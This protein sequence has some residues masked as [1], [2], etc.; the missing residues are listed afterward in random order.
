MLSAHS[1]R[2][3]NSCND[4]TDQD[5]EEDDGEKLDSIIAVEQLQ[6]N[7]FATLDASLDLLVRHSLEK[8]INDMRLMKADV[9]N[10][11]EL[12]IDECE[13]SQIK[14]EINS[15]QTTPNQTTTA[16]KESTKT[17]LFTIENIIKK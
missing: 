4:D 16:T 8:S 5:V 12:P 1:R 9:I 11:G 2:I 14:T 17:T 7:Y 6:K 13:E 15:V 3:I 10:N